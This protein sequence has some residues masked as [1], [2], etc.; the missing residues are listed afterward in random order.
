MD[1]L[2][3]VVIIDGVEYTQ[4]E[5]DV[6][7]EFCG[8]D[9]IGSSSKNTI[10]SFL[11][12]KDAGNESVNSY[13]AKGAIPLSITTAE[14][15]QVF[16]SKVETLYS[17]ACKYGASHDF[18]QRPLYREEQYYHNIVGDYDY[19]TDLPRK[20]EWV[21]EAF[22]SFSKS[23]G[24][25]DAFS[26]GEFASHKI[27]VHGSDSEAKRNIPFIDVN[28]LLT[29]DHVFSGEE[30]I[31]LPPY[32]DFLV[33][34]DA[35]IVSRNV[36]NFSSQSNDYGMIVTG[37]MRNPYT[38]ARQ[39][40]DGKE[41]SPYSSQDF[42]VTSAELELIVDLNKRAYSKE[43][44]LTQEEATTLEK[45]TEKLRN[46]TMTRCKSIYKMQ[47]EHPLRIG[48]YFTKEAATQY[49]FVLDSISSLRERQ[50]R[51]YTKEDF[52]KSFSYLEK[53]FMIGRAKS[54]KLSNYKFIDLTKGVPQEVVT[55][56]LDSGHKAGN[57][58]MV[59]ALASKGL[60]VDE[61]LAYDGKITPKGLENLTYLSVLSGPEEGRTKP[62]LLS[63]LR[64]MRETWGYEL[65]SG[66]H[67][68]LYEVTEKGFTVLRDDDDR[69]YAQEKAKSD[70]SQLGRTRKSS[71][72]AE[73]FGAYEEYSSREGKPKEQQT[74]DDD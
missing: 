68:S 33:D 25:S 60:I 37:E 24:E 9:T 31:L 14:D 18:P 65:F 40:S 13:L 63:D 29:E 48:Q 73:D 58:E 32:Q 8:R 6:L 23:R 50:E 42:D 47:M 11:G 1:K 4:R 54:E 66:R 51:I 45:L 16:L 39:K 30:E 3:E 41:I 62:A 64:E 36:R 71:E 38:V 72:I 44:P 12:I 57:R 2:D 21:S 22:K 35:S 19:R 67:T 49:G 43:N 61:V 74:R 52:D 53:R 15:L 27:V 28:N 17:V 20:R 26:K 5:L 34:E 56:V 70:L 69:I 59:E 10:S 7:R 55:S 46:Y